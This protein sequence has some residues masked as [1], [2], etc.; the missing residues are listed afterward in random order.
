[1]IDGAWV[2]PENSGLGW[3]G[4]SQ[5]R[6]QAGLESTPNQLGFVC[7]TD[8]GARGTDG[9]VGRSASDDKEIL[10]GLR[11]QRACEHWW[12]AEPLAL[13]PALRGAAL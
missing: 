7:V 12:M 11:R 13:G 10:V 5:W 4:V 8:A 6:G 9:A 3:E 2:C 1:V